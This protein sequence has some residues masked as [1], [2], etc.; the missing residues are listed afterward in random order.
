MKKLFLLCLI[1]TFAFTGILVAEDVKTEVKPKTVEIELSLWDRM[2]LTN[3]LPQKGV[4]ERIV[5]I[6]DLNEKLTLTQDEMDICEWKT[7]TNQF[8]YNPKKAKEFKKVISLTIREL[9]LLKDSFEKLNNEES[10]PADKDFIALY[11][12]IIDL[13]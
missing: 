1:A 2:Q 4:Y 5:T 7:L 8:Q 11:E 12:K 9:R 3:I 10:L 6:R 13:K